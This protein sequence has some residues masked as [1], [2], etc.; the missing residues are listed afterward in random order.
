MRF[1][2]TS[3]LAGPEWR[4]LAPVCDDPTLSWDVFLGRPRNRLE[5]AVRHPAPA[6]WRAATEAA[7]A[8]RTTAQPTAL[9]SHLPAMAAATNVMRRAL[10]PAV[11]HIAFAFN[12]TKLPQGIRRSFLTRALVGIDEFVVFSRFER[13][14]YA[15]ELGIPEDRI[16]FLP[17]AMD[18]P[19]P[20][21]QTPL[22]AEVRA[23][24]YLAAIGGEGRDYA[25]LAEV[26]RARPDQR[27]VIVTRPYSI[28]GIRFPENVTVFTNLPGPDTWRIAADAQALVIPL[29][30]DT[31]ACGHIT[32][33]GA[34]LLGLPL[35][36]TRSRGVEDYVTGKTA[37]MVPAGDGA[38]LGAALD[39][40]LEY[41]TAMAGMAAIA[42]VKAET[43]NALATWVAYFRDVA[44]LFVASQKVAG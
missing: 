13:P 43:E 22:T 44:Q 40:G 24:G 29:L 23:R 21:P 27:M 20:G 35:I 19:Q 36:V 38:A 33:V 1:L 4:F 8:A 15:A 31:T 17:W 41:P 37:Q 7:W 26:M 9:V 6:R 18:A 2:N 10:C 12:F 5:R 14:L 11:P 25:L 42:R 32:M 3:D 28:T 16:R 34:Q 39:R 30:S